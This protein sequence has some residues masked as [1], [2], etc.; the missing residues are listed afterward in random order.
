M[1]IAPRTTQLLVERGEYV[2][3]QAVPLFDVRPPILAGADWA[4]KRSFDLVVAALIVVIG[5]PFWLVIALLIKVTSRGPVFYAD[6]RV[7]L[8]ER[9]LPDAQ[10]PDDGRGRRGPA[11]RARAGERGERRAVQDPRRPARDRASGG[12]CGASRSTRSR[13]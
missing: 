10:V 12:C 13:T 4:L 2:P 6:E 8:G 9:E 5:L 11:G 3:G 1:R 7:G